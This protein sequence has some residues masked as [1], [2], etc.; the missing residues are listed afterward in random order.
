MD[1]ALNDLKRLI[2][3][4][5]QTTDQPTNQ[6]VALEKFA[7]RPYNQVV[8]EDVRDRLFHYHIR[9]TLAKFPDALLLVDPGE[10]CLIIIAVCTTDLRNWGAKY[11]F[12]SS[13]MVLLGRLRTGEGNR[14]PDTPNRI[15]CPKR[16]GTRPFL[17]LQKRYTG[18]E[19]LK[20]SKESWSRCVSHTPRPWTLG[21]ASFMTKGR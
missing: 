14:S 6:Y 9:R 13:H 20:D 18:E 17:V 10:R 1:L 7:Q 16:S 2:C 5:T 11:G 4:K 21:R 3:C 8:K 12:P 19:A 15:V